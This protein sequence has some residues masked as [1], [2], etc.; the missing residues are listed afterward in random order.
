[1]L[2]YNGLGRMGRLGNQMF[3]YA[4]L[5]GIARNRGFDFCIPWSPFLDPWQDH[6]LL[7]V[8]NLQYGLTLDSP[9]QP[10]TMD[11]KSFQFDYELF[12]YVEDNTDI[13]GYLQTERYFS[14]IRDEL[15]EDFSFRQD[16]MQTSAPGWTVVHVRRGDYVNLQQFHPTCTL[17]YYREAMEITGGPFL[18]VSDDIEWCKENIPAD[19]Y[20]Y[21]SNTQD[22]YTMTK[23]KNNIIANSSFSWW[24][25]WLNQNPDKIVIA[26]KTW[27]GAGYSHD[28]SDLLPESWIKV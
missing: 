1:M 4:S 5:K 7:E 2:S 17:D 19:G 8:F 21:S 3:Q 6:Q 15:L 16:I 24:G 25:A 10:R 14:H 20:S 26:P 23:A 22:L 12:N 11:E 28:T 13:G 18:I 27:F 9:S